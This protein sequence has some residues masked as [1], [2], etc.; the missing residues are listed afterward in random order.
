MRKTDPDLWD[1]WTN[2]EILMLELR[3]RQLR[4]IFGID[5]AILGAGA[6][7][8]GSVLGS[9][10]QSSANS[11]NAQNVQKQMDFQ[12]YM[13]GTAHQREVNDLRAAGLNPLLAVNGGASTPTG[14]AA[15]AQP[16][17]QGDEISKG[18][19]S[20]IEYKRMQ[21]EL[22]ATDSTIKLNTQA[23]ATSKENAKLASAN[24]RSANAAATMAEQNIK[25]NAA[26]SEFREKKARLDNDYAEYDSIGNRASRDLDTVTSALDTFTR[27][28]NRG[29]KKIT[30]RKSTD[31]Q[32]WDKIRSQPKELDR[33][34]Y[35]Q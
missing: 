25:A 27:F 7:I 32:I 29:S 24:T 9:A 21:K 19:S 16:T 3:P 30:P 15:V 6:S 1:S 33:K 18:L 35:S 5:D 10:S 17:I 12:Q 4:D 26:E 13:S 23:E 34:L 20:A 2:G 8:F 22:D 11:T 28:K 31:E 14:A